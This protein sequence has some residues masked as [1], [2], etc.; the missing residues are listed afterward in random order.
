MARFLI[1]ALAAITLGSAA[2]AQNAPK[3]ISRA[4]YVK[5]VSGRFNTMDTNH[6]GKISKDE[7]VVQQQK[8]LAQARANLEAK[9]RDAFKRLDTNKDGV[10][11]LPEFLGSASTINTTETPDQ[12]LQ[13]LDSN[14]DGKVSAE[15]FL[16]PEL[17]KFN[18]VDANH[19]GVVTPDEVRAANGR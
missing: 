9:L 4:D 17:A 10:L 18:K 1:L 12:L 11:S 5:L 16:G 19:D 13:R 7:F 6:D 8:D 14:H 15:E 3:P 2:A